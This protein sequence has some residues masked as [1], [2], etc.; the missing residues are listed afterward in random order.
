MEQYGFVALLAVTGLAAAAYDIRF[1]RIPN[2]LNLFIFLAGCIAIF[3]DPYSQEAWEHL[4]HFVIALVAAMA[5]FRLGLWGGGDAKFYA[6]VAVWFPL[7]KALM[8]ALSVALV[9]ALLVIVIAATS[10]GK[11]RKD[12]FEAL[13]YGVAIA[14][15]A[16]FVRTFELIA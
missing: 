16:L 9:G 12:L 2:W 8:L 14:I 11:R 7:S 1:R 3:V 6:A 15:G 5:L 10:T 13:P 4:G